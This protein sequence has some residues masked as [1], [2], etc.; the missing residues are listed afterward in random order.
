MTQ[1]GEGSALK[2]SPH[3]IPKI[4]VHSLQTPSR[5]ALVCDWS[6][7]SLRPIAITADLHYP[8]ATVSYRLLGPS[9]V[10]T[11][12][13]SSTPGAFAQNP[14][15]S[16]SSSKSAAAPAPPSAD[17]SKEAFVIQQLTTKV[18]FT[19]DGTWTSDTVA[20]TRIQ[21]QAGVQNFS[22][23]TFP[24]ASANA[25]IDIPYVRVRKPNGTVVVTPPE[26]IQDMPADV[27]R[28]APLYSDIREKQVAVKA[29]DV[30]DVL[31]YEYTIRVQKPLVPGQ[32]W[33]DYDFFKTG[34]ALHEDLQISVPRGRYVN[35]Q[36]TRVKPAISDQK[37]NTVYTWTAANLTSKSPEQK[38]ALQVPDK[39]PPP[40]VLLTTFRSWDEVAKWFHALEQ[41]QIASTA[42]IRAK[43]AELSGATSTENDKLRAIYNYVSL[44]I[45]YVGLDFGLGRYQ[46]HL[47]ADIL[48]NEY[49]D[50]KDKQ[51]LLTSLLGAEG[52]KS[53]PVLIN[54]TR[55]IDPAV[56]SPGQ[57]DH[58]IAVVPQGKDFV[59]LDAT[60]EVAPFGFL[61]ANLRNENALIISD[62]GSGQIVRTPV[63]PPFENSW[64][65]QMTGTLSDDGTLQA[66]AKA[67][68]RGDNEYLLRLAFRR[69]PQVQWKDL[70]QRLSYSWNFG[71]DVS[72]PSISPPDDTSSPF[73][74]GYDYTRKNYGAWDSKQ[75]TVPMPPIFLP[76]VDDKAQTDTK[77]I[78]LGFPINVSF[79]ATV[80]IPK[81]YN[82]TPPANLNLV[83]DFAEY[84]STYS[85]LDG[86]LHA[87]RHLIVKAQEVPWARHEYYEKFAKSIRDEYANFIT[88]V[89]LNNGNTTASS[90]SAPSSSAAPSA[91]DPLPD[92]QKAYQEGTQAW[93]ER[94]IN[95]ALSDFQRTI[96]LDPQYGPGWTSLGM[97]H[98][99]SHNIDQGLDE[100]K[101]A[102]RVDPGQTWGYTTLASVQLAMH[103]SED[104]LQTWQQ[105]EKT[106]P[107]NAQAPANAGRI[108]ISLKRYS[109]AVPELE[110]AVKANSSS[111]QLLS[112]L[113]TAYI[114]TNAP[115]K[116]VSA[117][118]QALKLD[119]SALM[120]NEVA[121]SLADANLHL[122]EAMRDATNA[123]QQEEN[124]TSKISV[125]SVSY[126][127]LQNMQLLG[128]FWDTLGWAHFRQG[129]LDEAE[130]YVTAAWDLDQFPDIGDHLGQIY[131]KEGKLQ[132]AAQLYAF[133]IAS[134]HA[135]LVAIPTSQSPSRFIVPRPSDQMPETY[136][137]LTA[138]LKRLPQS[139]SS[140][141][142]PNSSAADA[143]IS[144]ARDKL[145][146]LRTV[147]L[148]RIVP[149]ASEAEFF[150]VFAKG[151]KVVAMKFLSGSDKLRDDGK[152]LNTAKF[153]IAF[154]DN[155]PTLLIRRGVLDCETEL[156]YCQ[157]VMYPP[158]SVHSIN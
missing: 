135:P 96:T 55:E 80:Q 133:A 66:K 27:T 22:V 13:L 62:E 123:V 71:G 41:P 84:H 61:P 86:T 104:A 139:K 158:E 20:E 19:N 40:D 115:D 95:G 153:N 39:T 18:A 21:S 154:P 10:V 14:L 37:G 63:N 150:V 111:A 94:D 88:L 99:A 12:L 78:R 26:T 109:E 128:A 113:G 16:A 107:Q 33:F 152:V 103:R 2:P 64:D 110:Q 46:P 114:K 87:E 24:Y 155:G 156:R 112:F 65:Y 77:P 144:E 53:F 82:L 131:E 47:A 100:M 130:K 98:L 138:V 48:S 38:P 126:Q 116:A 105:L 9:L 108:L 17:Y 3:P 34:I 117:Y 149:D 129:H 81:N 102:I 141:G 85:F 70:L 4:Q 127:D 142:L 79:A 124:S 58:V 89:A 106:D 93:Q 83:Q 50:C 25:V 49:G 101:K 32:F 137:R 54:S 146:E 36:S 45:R 69:T 73:A 75:I 29:L 140:T 60:A 52:I 28:E 147:R 136:N 59:W 5:T 91:H 119:S 97:A 15:P 8:S 23:L 134:Y 57:F 125:D 68:F 122:D 72:D 90:A 11:V 30:G 35:V 6:H 7:L 92:A 51:T 43:A 74:I 148:Q 151:P 132:Q 145:S 31:E 56:P 44:K 157:F 1:N 120:L 67:N 121:F 76:D 143:A 42:E 118:S